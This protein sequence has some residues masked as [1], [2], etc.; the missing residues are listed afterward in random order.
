MREI[1]NKIIECFRAGHFLYAIGNG[2]S[3]TMASHFCGELIEVAEVE[4]GSDT[5]QV[6][7]DLE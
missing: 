3:A 7:E 2:G 4:S 5:E 6:T 1:A